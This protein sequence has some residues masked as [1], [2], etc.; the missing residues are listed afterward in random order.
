MSI[1]HSYSPGTLV[2]EV[3][4]S[5]P[6]E[7]ADEYLEWLHLF[8]KTQVETIPG[9]ISSMIFRQPKP[10]GLHWL[11]E[12]GNTKTYMTVHYVIASQADLDTYLQNDQKAVA[13]AEQE[14][15]AFLVTSRRTLSV[16]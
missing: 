14:R 12:E 9:F 16:V 11:S 8:T 1:P 15:F 3:N 10:Y 4:L 7:K 13:T 2:Y 6:R 5:V